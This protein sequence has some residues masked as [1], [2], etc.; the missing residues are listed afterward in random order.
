MDMG[1]PFITES[2]HKKHLHRASTFALFQGTKYRITESENGKG[3]IWH[4]ELNTIPA[5][6]LPGISWNGAEHWW[7][8]QHRQ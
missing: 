2:T 1:A 8:L 7:C 4:V 3:D 6:R 5:A